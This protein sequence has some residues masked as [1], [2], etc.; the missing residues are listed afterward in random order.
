M[1]HKLKNGFRSYVAYHAKVC[2][3]ELFVPQWGP[4]VASQDLLNWLKRN[5]KKM[6][7]GELLE[8][9]LEKFKVLLALGEE[10]RRKNQ[11]R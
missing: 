3:E 5:R 8:P 9:R 11:Y 10:Y 1:Q 4:K 2:K 6:N 7:A